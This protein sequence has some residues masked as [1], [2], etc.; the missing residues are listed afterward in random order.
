MYPL[1]RLRRKRLYSW[2]RDLVAE[3]LIRSENFI[4]PLFV[5]EGS[6]IKEEIPTMPGVYRMS[7]DLVVEEVKLAESL[8]IRAVALFPVVGQNLKTER[9]EES[10]NSDNLVCR[11]VQAIKK[12]C[13]NIGVICDVALDPYTTHGHDGIVSGSDVDNDQTIEVLCKQAVALCVAGADII[14]PSDMMDGR[15]GVIRNAIDEANYHN[16]S[17]LSY[18]TKYASSFYGPFR[19]AI[20]SA[21][22]LAKANKS[23]YQMD[24][25]NI[26]E[27]LVEIEFDINEGADMIMV[28]PG[29]PYLDVISEASKTFS[30]PIFA[31]QVSGEYAMMKHAANAGCFD[32]K[33]VMMESLL[34]F[35]R[36]GATAIFTYAALEIAKEINNRS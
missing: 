26:K 23:T 10:Y 21:K 36:A 1:V 3:T 20:G 4:Y 12:S 2:M 30:V 19:D 18:A 32:F 31:Y 28:K 24:P 22:N 25:K 29:M 5:I 14:A 8:G 15:I 33:N 9:A 7:I 11:T 13:H 6:N 27:A 16:I 34:S 17:I 35:R